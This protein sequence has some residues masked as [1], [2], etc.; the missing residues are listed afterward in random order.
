[1]VTIVK[2]LLLLL[3]FS[4]MASKD[5]KKGQKTPITEKSSTYGEFDDILISPR[6]ISLSLSFIGEGLGPGEWIFLTVFNGHVLIETKWQDKHKLTLEE[7]PLD[8]KRPSCQSLIADR[9]LVFLL[10]V[11]GGKGAKDPDPL[12]NVDNRAGASADL[13]PLVLGEEEVFV[14]APFINFN[15]GIKTDCAIK[16]YAKSVGEPDRT[17]IPLMITMISAHCL[18]VLREGTVFISAIGLNDISE[19]VAANF[20]MSLSNSDV[21]T[22][23]WA[24]TNNG[25]SVAST[26][27]NIPNEDVFIPPDLQLKNNKFCNSYYWNAMKRVLVDSTKLRERLRS[28]FLIDIAGVP[29]AGKID[30]RGRYMAFVDAGVLLEPGQFGV[31]TCA[32][33]LY[34]NECNLPSDLRGL[35][36]LPPASAKISARETDLVVDENGHSAYITLRFDLY[37]PLT[38]KAKIASLYN[39]IGFPS[40]QDSLI[41]VY[42]LYTSVFND[43]TSINVKKIKKECGALSV[44]KELGI[45]AYKGPPQ[46]T[47]S[48][49]R[50]A[51]NRLLFRVRSMLKQFPPDSCSSIEC[52]DIITA[53]HAACRR[54]VTASFA[55]QPPLPCV[56]PPVASA[57]NRIAGDKRIAEY[58]IK[59]NLEANPEHPRPLLAKILHCLEDRN[60]DEARNSLLKALSI[61]SKNRYLLWIFGGSEFNNDSS[62]E[63][64]SAALRIAA[65]CDVSEGTTGTI[66]WAALHTFHHH[67]GNIYAA[68]VAARKMRKSFELPKEWKKFYRQWVDISGEETFWIPDIVDSTNPILIAAAFFLCLRCY[69]LS[70][71]LLKCV[72]E[73][74]CTRG[75]RLNVKTHDTVDVFYLRAV[76]LILRRQ[77]NPA[78]DVI[79]KG[80]RKYGPSPM[81]SHIRAVC[82]TYIRGW[83]EMCESALIESDRA[84]AE[85]CPYLLLKAALG[86]LMKDPAVA[87][88]RAGR[89]HKIAPSAHTALTIGRAYEKLGEDG[90]AERWA[91]AAVNLEPLLSD[92]WA[93]L[94]FLAINDRNINRA[95]A[96]LRTAKQAGPI[97]PDIEEDLRKLRKILRVDTLPD[98]L[99]KDLCFCDYY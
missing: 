69:K 17:R 16:V 25:G 53:Q 80:I 81:M 64:A 63:I 11:A 59:K 28:P 73:G 20:G 92:G 45:I 41:P 1:M 89:A 62:G 75:S 85:I 23:L 74:C 87:L 31:T 93:F 90:L 77:L 65:K 2:L 19:P 27:F 72:E 57:R 3:L 46:A 50:T 91:A 49:K 36:E 5:A 98:A 12:L 67:K 9:P 40:P 8:L 24:S 33:L 68:F 35:L 61:Q 43:D 94:A 78:L 38:A 60:E 66:G 26:S 55:P 70:E 88:Q 37:F 42:E 76:S 14:E 18:P 39:I 56:S 96:M 15:T 99:V 7:L 32:K 71:R 34:Y 29:R 6:S 86:N 30:V 22:I 79:E 10:R 54:A 47:Q 83:D 97:N 82:L 21:K 52:Q 51:A 13:F 4:N 58:H 95:A 48:V 84:G 44:H